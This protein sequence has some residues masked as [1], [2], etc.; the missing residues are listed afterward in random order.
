LI[1]IKEEYWTRGHKENLT[2]QRSPIMTAKHLAGLDHALQLAHEWINDLDSNLGWSD[3]PRTYRLLR[4]VLHAVR[5]WLP[6]NEAADL[7]AQLP[8]LIRGIYYDQWRPARTPVKPRDL[9][10]FLGRVDAAFEADPIDDPEWAISSVFAY[11]SQRISE[12][13]IEDVK[14]ALPASVRSLWS[15]T[16]RAA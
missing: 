10:V 3:K 7:G 14:Q 5:D 6:V 16:L 11:L 15:L 2:F 9:P 12:G 1:K 8:L 13:E 4:T